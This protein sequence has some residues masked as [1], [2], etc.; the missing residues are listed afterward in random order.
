MCSSDLPHS[1]KALPILYTALVRST[2]SSPAWTKPCVN[3][4][5]RVSRKICA[6]AWTQSLFRGEQGMGA[7]DGAL[8]GMGGAA[9]SAGDAL[10][11]LGGPWGFM[12]GIV[13]KL[14]GAAT[15]AAKTVT[16][17]SDKEFQAY[18]ELSRV[19]AATSRGLTQTRQ[20]A[21]RMGLG[22]EELPKFVSLISA[23]SQDLA[24]FGGGVAAGTQALSDLGAGLQQDRQKFMR[25]GYTTDMMNEGAR[26][27]E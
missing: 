10:L 15:R 2:N 6:S 24:R 20:D 4:R 3:S 5:L 12:A 21:K 22:V 11:A 17:Q 16:A 13:L 23:N 7:M 9:S 26:S 18:Q 25:L 1:S 8:D 19:G 14:I 27:S